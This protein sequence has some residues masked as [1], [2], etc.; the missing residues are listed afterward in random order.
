[1]QVLVT[2]SAGFLGSELC[3]ELLRRN[4]RPI[5]GWH[6]RKPSTEPPIQEIRCDV[7][8]LADVT[9]AVGRADAVIHAAYL[10]GG[11]GTDRVNVDGSLLVAEQSALRGK[12][13]IHISTDAVFAGRSQP[14]AEADPASPLPGYTYGEQ[15][16][17][18]ETGVAAILASAT[19]V[20]TS[21]MY[22]RRGISPIEQQL[23]RG[24]R[25]DPPMR[26]FADEFRR[27][28]HVRDVAASVVALLGVDAPPMIHLA[29]PELLSRYEIALRLAPVLGIPKSLILRGSAEEQQLRRPRV[30]DLASSLA[31]Q[32][33]DFRPQPLPAG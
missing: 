17:A 3:A 6:H 8:S 29:G 33:I 15:K 7:I 24:A 2:G 16:A 9:E 18:A 11:C 31:E 21:L 26:H 5:A 19:I 25:S 13:L 23:I 10:P 4:H 12:R 28:V 32:L 27:P 20:R 22:G 1:M 14:Y 30:I